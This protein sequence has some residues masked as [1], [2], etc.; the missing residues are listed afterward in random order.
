MDDI[1]KEKIISAFKDKK[2]DLESIILSDEIQLTD[3]EYLLLLINMYENK[4]AE[5]KEINEI[6]YKEIEIIN[7][8]ISEL[9]KEMIEEYHK[10]ELNDENSIIYTNGDIKINITKL[11]LIECLKNIR[12]GIEF[13]ELFQ[14]MYISYIKLNEN[15][16]NTLNIKDEE[17]V[18]YIIS[19]FLRREI[20]L[21]QKEIINRYRNMRLAHILYSS[22]ENKINN[23]EELISYLKEINIDKEYYDILKENYKDDI[24]TED[25]IEMKTEEILEAY[26]EALRT[27]KINYVEEMLLMIYLKLIDNKDA[28]EKVKE[29]NIDSKRFKIL[30]NEAIYKLALYEPNDVMDFYLS[31]NHIFETNNQSIFDDYL[32]DYEYEE[33][34]E[35]ND[36]TEDN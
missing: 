6:N 34:M 16:F 25:E 35:E 31:T 11:I 28:K 21:Y 2:I 7:P 14:E 20:L 15:V 12:Y 29:L 3:E 33:E 18:K 13:I 8:Y 23:E 22:I 36:F 1:L 17:L 26:T 27:S 4:I 9:T 30:L 32:E 10:M 5:H 24:L 19:Q